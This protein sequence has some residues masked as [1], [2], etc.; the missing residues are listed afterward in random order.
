MT[1]LKTLKDLHGVRGISNIKLSASQGEPIKTDIEV[2]SKFVSED[3]LRQ[4]AIKHIIDLINSIE[5][6]DNN[7]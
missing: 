4:E 5:Y 1:E 3:D 6:C 7:A 2:S